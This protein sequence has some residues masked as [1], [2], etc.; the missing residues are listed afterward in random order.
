MQ[1]HFVN[2]MQNIATES[3]VHKKCSEYIANRKIE[4][5]E[6]KGIQQKMED[7]SPMN[8]TF[9][10]ESTTKSV[11]IMHRVCCMRQNASDIRQSR[12]TEIN[13]HQRIWIGYTGMCVC[14]CEI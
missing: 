4:A 1:T 2:Y 7:E 12:M 8:L 3:F 9:K 11:R 6:R 10:I 14:V 13:T 5:T